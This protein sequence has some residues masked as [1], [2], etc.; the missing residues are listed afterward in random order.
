M[1]Y[2]NFIPWGISLISLV[3]VALTYKHNGDKDNRKEVQEEDL[4]FDGIKESLLKAN[5]KL[6]QLCTTTTE[7]RTDIKTLNRDIVEMDRRVTIIERDLKTAFN[8]IDEMKKGQVK[9][10]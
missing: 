8:Q 5:L 10:V 3:F 7:T 6:D 9:S 4:K 2:W 1:N